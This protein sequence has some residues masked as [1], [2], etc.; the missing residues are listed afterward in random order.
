MEREIAHFA[1]ENRKLQESLKEALD[2]KTDLEDRH[3]ILRKSFDE[4]R[5]SILLLRDSCKTSYYNLAE[6]VDRT[7]R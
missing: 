7:T 5:E 4:V 3:E 2:Q 6:E 1:E